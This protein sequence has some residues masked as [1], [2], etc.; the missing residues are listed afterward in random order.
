MFCNNFGMARLLYICACVCVH[1]NDATRAREP[2]WPMILTT[3]K[4]RSYA[5]F[6]N[7]PVLWIVPTHTF[8]HEFQS[9][10]IL[11][12]YETCEW[13]SSHVVQQI[14]K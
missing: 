9:P 11:S 6:S 10:G 14:L 3:D 4:L 12:A 1:L 7:F 8:R 13:V 5:I 2:M